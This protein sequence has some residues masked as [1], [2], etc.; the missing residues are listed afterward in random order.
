VKS[1]SKPQVQKI[2]NEMDYPIS[3]YKFAK[4][5]QQKHKEIN[6]EWSGVRNSGRNRAADN[7]ILITEK[8]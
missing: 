4:A 1:L 6:H 5:I 2:I 7:Q 8:K 3:L